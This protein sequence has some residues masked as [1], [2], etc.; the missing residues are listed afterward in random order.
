MKCWL[1]LIVSALGVGAVVAFSVPA[2]A[3]MSF[4][5]HL[6]V[7]ATA[8][9]LAMLNHLRAKPQIMPPKE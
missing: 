4:W 1:N 8:G 2:E 5:Q 9:G 3:G 6:Q 7:A